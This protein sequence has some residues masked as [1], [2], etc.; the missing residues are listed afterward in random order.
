M[1]A[2]IRIT[3]RGKQKDE[4]KGEQMDIKLGNTVIAIENSPTYRDVLVADDYRTVIIGLGDDYTIK[5]VAI[6]KNY[7]HVEDVFD[8]EA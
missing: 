8:G 4:N 2:K 3:Y 5:R 1:R 7:S 6:Q